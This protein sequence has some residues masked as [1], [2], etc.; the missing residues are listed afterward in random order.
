MLSVASPPPGFDGQWSAAGGVVVRL[1]EHR[2]DQQAPSPFR[3]LQKR[4]GQERTDQEGAGQEG[5]RPERVR[6][7]HSGEDCHCE[8]Q[9]GPVYPRYVCARRGG[10][11]KRA[12][13]RDGRRCQYTGSVLRHDEGNIDHVVPRSRGGASTWDNCVLACIDCNKRKADRT[14]GQ[15][16]LKLRKPPVRPQWQPLYARHSVRIASWSKFISEAYWNVEL[17]S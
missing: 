12:R 13:E 3:P 17:K 4:V 8:E 1:G 5:V 16:G 2:T 9:G 6:P 7:E 14:P 10:R 15:A 11:S